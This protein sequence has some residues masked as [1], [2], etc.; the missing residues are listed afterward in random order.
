MSGKHA[1]FRIIIL[2][3]ARKFSSSN[4]SLRGYKSLI[5]IICQEHIS[6]H[7]LPINELSKTL[8]LNV[9]FDIVGVDQ[10]LLNLIF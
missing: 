8:F 10:S 4:L 5:L 7:L 9:Y 2:Q 3:N 1:I 6:G